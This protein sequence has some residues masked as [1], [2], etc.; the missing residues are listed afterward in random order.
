MG[1]MLRLRLKVLKFLK[2]YKPAYMLS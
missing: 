1:L 2:C